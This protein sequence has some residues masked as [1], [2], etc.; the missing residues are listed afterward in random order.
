MHFSSM[1]KIYGRWN[2]NE[3]ETFTQY[4][5]F[6]YTQMHF[7]QQWVCVDKASTRMIP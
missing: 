6:T 1:D 5:S 3:M 4:S 7:K 2:K